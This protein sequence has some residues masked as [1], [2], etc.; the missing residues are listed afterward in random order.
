MNVM[1]DKITIKEFKQIVDE[2]VPFY[3]KRRIRETGFLIIKGILSILTKNNLDSLPEEISVNE[4]TPHV[5]IKK[6]PKVSSTNYKQCIDLYINKIL[7][8]LYIIGKAKLRILLRHTPKIIFIELS[9]PESEIKEWFDNKLDNQKRETLLKYFYNELPISSDFIM[10]FYRNFEGALE[11]RD[12]NKKEFY[13][14]CENEVEFCLVLLQALNEA[15]KKDFW[16]LYKICM[17][18]YDKKKYKSPENS[19]VKIFRHRDAYYNPMFDSCEPIREYVYLSSINIADIDYDPFKITIGSTKWFLAEV[20]Y[21][22]E[23]M[24]YIKVN[25]KQKYCEITEKGK[26][27]LKR[28]INKF[29]K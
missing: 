23:Q 20:L 26:K 7:N 13:E 16:E 25:R 11:K 3:Q 19:K 5:W 1:E 29:N 8:N 21:G 12:V 2:F 10:E 24:E 4:L 6:H 22:L 9:K 28:L 15:D 14:Y 18:N 17:N 27:E